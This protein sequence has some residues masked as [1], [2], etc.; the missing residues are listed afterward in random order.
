MANNNH[1][2]AD[3]QLRIDTLVGKVTA[4]SVGSYEHWRTLQQAKNE[5]E[6][7]CQT[8]GKT[9]DVGA[10]YAWLE[11][12]YGIRLE[13]IEGMIGPDFNIIDEQKYLVYKLKF[14]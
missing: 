11:Q 7:Q 3:K 6:D 5:F 2:Y 13:K 10:F 8:Q 14:V 12:N 4:T 1:L 9:Y